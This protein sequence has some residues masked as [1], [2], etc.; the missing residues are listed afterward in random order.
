MS[1]Y[2][3]ERFVAEQ[4]ES[5][6]S[7]TYSDIRLTIRDDGSKDST[8]DILSR[9]AATDDRIKFVLHKNVGIVGSFYRLLQDADPECQFVAFADQDDVWM[10]DKVER[11]VQVLS[12]YDNAGPLLYCANLEYV[13]TDLR[14]LGYSRNIARKA[15]LNNAL[16]Q[17]IAQ[18]CTV[19]INDAA[20]K[21][22]LKHA[23]P[24]QVMMHDWWLYVVVSAFGSVIRDDFISMKYRQHEGNVIGGTV[25]F[26]SDFRKR[27]SN[28]INRNNQSFFGCYP[29]AN[30]F[31]KTYGG[32]LAGESREV[33]RQFIDSRKSLFRRIKYL[34]CKQRVYRQTFT[35]NL[36]LQMLILINR[37]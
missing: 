7:Q 1:T 22:L 24:P 26:F 27:I 18:G 29:Q 33:I 23:W 14:H 12:T 20:R 3:G 30:G 19:V 5:I 11:A 17:N 16:V 2:N 4:I 6:L 37:Y 8:P 28:F 13:S 36:I 25:T 10:P 32:E 15:G 9:Y 21:L 34:S 31:W 35:D